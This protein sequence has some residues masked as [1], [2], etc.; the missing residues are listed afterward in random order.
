MISWEKFILES[1]NV[2]NMTASQKEK[3]AK[4]ILSDIKKKKKEEGED[5]NQKGSA[6]TRYLQKQLKFKMKKYE[7]QKKRQK[8]KSKE[9][10]QKKPIE[11]AKKALSA[12][13]TEKVYPKDTTATATKKS[14]GN[15]ASFIGGVAKAAAHGSQAMSARKKAE[16]EK[17]KQPEKR[18]RKSPGRPKVGVPKTQKNQTTSDT[19]LISGTPSRK[20]LIPSTKKLPP[21]TKKIAPSGGVP[22][23]APPEPK[24]ET[25]M[26]L[27]QRARRNPELKKR[28][29]SVREKTEMFYDWRKDFLYEAEI[30][31]PAEESDGKKK[32]I[33]DVLKNSKNKLNKIEINPNI[34]EDHKEIESG[35]KKD[36]EGYMANVEL[37]SMER[38]I[39]ALRKKITKSDMQM[40]AWV[41][42]KIT[43]AADYIDTASE[44]LQSDEK[45]SEETEKKKYC[46]LCRKKETKSECSYG[47]SMWEKY[48]ISEGKVDKK[49]MKCNKPKA[50]AHGS[51]ETGK[52]H[53]VKACQGGEEKI[54]RFGQL[55]VKGSPKKEGE[56]EAYASR[57][58]RFQARHAK[59]IA[60]G[61]MSAAW[62][63]SKVKW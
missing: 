47:P 10:A 38:A 12:I 17:S 57:R 2:K 6:H 42:S 45:L 18:E 54:I 28:L 30:S 31:S 41:Q 21:A 36:D 60:K 22:Y 20:R 32:K 3:A 16:Q 5:K 35:K 9:L 33:I 59:N 27:G 37:D 15:I 40:P 14:L 43:R 25:G 39:K 49:S 24:K 62:W 19:K 11:S 63:S 13:K 29:I 61:K 52:S 58:H 48:S 26:T 51:G 44:Y 55:G 8:E 1:E 23:Q 34:S 53:I 56:S 7:E 50:Q 4:K 46:K